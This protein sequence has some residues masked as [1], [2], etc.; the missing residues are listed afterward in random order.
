MKTSKAKLAQATY[1]KRFTAEDH[2]RFLN[3]KCYDSKDEAIN[4]LSPVEKLLI[5]K[6]EL[7]DPSSQICKIVTYPQKSDEWIW[8]RQG[9]LT[10]SMASACVGNSKYKK[11]LLQAQEMVHKK[12]FD[13]NASMK[14]GIEHEEIALQDYLNDLYFQ[15]VTTY[16]EVLTQSK[17]I[18][19]THFEFRNT[20]IPILDVNTDPRV[21][22]R[23]FGLIIDPHNH[24]R[25]MSPDGIIFINDVAVGC[26]EIK[27]P[28]H[29][30]QDKYELYPN[31]KLYYYDQIQ[32]QLYLAQIYWN[33]VR[34][35][36]FV[37]WTPKWFTVEFFVFDS[38]YFYGW[39]LP[40]E[41]RFYFDAY[42]PM[43]ADRYVS[44]YKQANPTMINDKNKKDLEIF[45][46][47]FKK[48]INE[49]FKFQKD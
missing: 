35:I 16:R 17:S 6:I 18:V 21:E 3:R 10:G 39:Y 30:T 20:L 37:C 34:W 23:Q 4:S 49:K 22:I 47:S 48:F 25:G 15:V 7:H 46:I 11:V 40:R 42:L 8:A 27:C 5:S 12:K 36:D 32:C 26:V 43:L 13:P 14:W 19:P 1:V 45:A 38:E 31:I 28:K 9:R 2:L 44:E 33:T 24:W 41:F 29:A